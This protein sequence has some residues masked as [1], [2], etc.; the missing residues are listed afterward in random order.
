MQKKLTVFCT[1]GLSNRLRVLTSGLALAEASGRQFTMLWPLTPDCAAGFADLFSNP[2]PVE[3]VGIPALEGLPYHSNWNG[4][5]PDLLASSETDLVIGHPTWLV[6]PDAFPGHEQLMARCQGLFGELQPV[7]ELQQKITA[8]REQHFQPGMIGVHLRRGDYLQ[9][10]PDQ[11][12]NTA[13]ALAAVDHF[14]EVD[15]QAGIFLCTD[16]GA[17]DQKTGRSLGR[18]GVREAFTRRYGSRVCWTTPRSLNRREPSA[19]QDALVDLWLLRAADYFVGTATSSFSGM[20]I[21]ARDVPCQFVGGA[22]PEYVRL[23][24]LARWTGLYRL[25]NALGR[26]KMGRKVPFSLL[27][28]YY[29]HYPIVLR[30]KLLKLLHLTK[31]IRRLRRGRGG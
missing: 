22:T 14:L 26:R 28:R 17:V 6:Q 27:Y 4:P 9:A 11:A 21:F 24:R 30:H 20:A 23:E 25:L 8:F 15:G 2:W 3:V 13:Q 1:S 7:A 5:L 16:D 29:S 31:L 18:E 12:G 19:I 10:R